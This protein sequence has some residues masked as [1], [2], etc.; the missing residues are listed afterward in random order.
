MEIKQAEAHKDGL[1][2]VLHMDAEDA[3]ERIEND[4]E[5]AACALSQRGPVG[6]Q[7]APQM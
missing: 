2:K 6:E 4:P 5:G 7:L 1:W 3:K